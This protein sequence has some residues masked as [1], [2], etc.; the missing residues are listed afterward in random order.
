MTTH[1]VLFILIA[2]L[3][4]SIPC[5]FIIYYVTEKKDIRLEGSGNTGA[6]NVLRTKGKKAAA[7]TLLCDMLKGALPIIY[8]MSHFE[9]PVVIACGGAAAVIGHIFPL[10]LKFKGGKGVATSLGMVLG[11]YPYYT[12]PGLMTFAIWAIVVLIWRYISLA[13][14]I[15]AAAFPAILIIMIIANSSRQWQFAGLWPL[16]LVAMLMA[17]LVVVRHVENIKRLLEGSESK[18]LQK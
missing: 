10:F 8:G 7:A 17:T 14:I 16:V 11:L 12:L 18:V 2:Y 1:E 13:S 5:G 15:A 3:V 4:G 6:T 9:S